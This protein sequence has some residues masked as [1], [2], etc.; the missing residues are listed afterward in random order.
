MKT[1][2]LWNVTIFQTLHS[3]KCK[4]FEYV[5][6]TVCVWMWTFCAKCLWFMAYISFWVRM[7]IHILDGHVENVP[8]QLNFVAAA[9]FEWTNLVLA[10]ALLWL[11]NG[12]IFKLVIMMIMANRWRKYSNRLALMWVNSHHHF[13]INTSIWMAKS[14]NTTHTH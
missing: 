13:Y 11:C 4:T 12:K 3:L 14:T 7:C 8:Y 5:A 6:V 10:V 2:I 9:A 1:L